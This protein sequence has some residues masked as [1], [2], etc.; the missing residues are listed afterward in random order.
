VRVSHGVPPGDVLVADVPVESALAN[1][2]W[3]CRA[4]PFPH[5]VATNVFTTE[6]YRRLEASF[7]ATIDRV[8]GRAYLDE[9]DI[10]GTTL[11]P[12]D[13]DAYSPLLSTGWHD[14][15][16]DMLGIPA[17]GHVMCG[18]H[19]H[20]IGSADGFPHNDLNP[21]WFDGDPRPG[22]VELSSPYTVDYTS[23]RI[24]DERADPRERVRAAALLFYLANDPWSPG[25][26]GETGLYRKAT[27]PVDRPVV[28]VPPVNNSLL[29]FECTPRSY[30]GFISN[31]R[32]SRNS[33]VMWLHRTKADAISRWGE[34]AITSYGL[35]P[36]SRSSTRRS[37]NDR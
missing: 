18:V 12:A 31:N 19:H 8:L 20:T 10:H 30:H 25:A 26:G 21:G 16:A 37:A 13:T 33:I 14:M 3:L 36:K 24:L 4:K 34:D 32:S 9:H 29:A 6:T 35:R 2:R 22:S 17:T 5:V 15:L 7:Q 27:D 1:R 28:R 23:G 11:L